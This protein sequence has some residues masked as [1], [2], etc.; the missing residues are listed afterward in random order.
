VVDDA[1]MGIT[2]VIRG[3]DHLNNTPRQIQIYQGL[4]YPLP[5]FGHVSMILGPDKKKLSKRHGAQSV[6]AYKKMGYL[7]QAVV[8]YLV[9]L[10]WSYGDQ[11]E[12]TREELIEK[13]SLG[14]VGKSAAAINPGKL[15]WL[16]AQYIKGIDLDE[17]IQRV[18]PFIE[19]KGYS[20]NDLNLLKKAVLSL[21][22]R[23]KTLVEMAD[24]S[25]FYFR[26]EI[27]YDEKAAEKFLKE[28]TVP[29]FKQIMSALLNEEILD[30]ASCHRLI[31][32]LAENRGEPLVKIAQPI[33]VALTGKTVSPPIDE[34]SEVLGKAKVIQRLQKAI[35]FIEHKKL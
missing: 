18:Q 26:E 13:F 31:Q 15:D 9:R 4:G 3:N 2:H 23:V 17:L 10:G 12:F 1:T 32:Q 33:R 35:A 21:R 8:N 24:L 20:I 28:E 11:E 34:V 16:N 25:E 14:A 5:G 29:L 19:A 27:T 6:M 30:K 22:E 7:P